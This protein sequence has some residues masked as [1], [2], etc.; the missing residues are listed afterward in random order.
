MVFVLKTDGTV[1]KRVVR[2]GIQDIT[3]IE[4]L[5][6]LKE[7]EEVVSDPYSAISKTLK[8]GTKVKVVPRE[9][10]FEK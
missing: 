6:G 9:E 3:Y 7:G 1:E 8:N 5:S 2:S 10:L 4:I